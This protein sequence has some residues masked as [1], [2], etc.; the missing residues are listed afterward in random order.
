[1]RYVCAYG[2]QDDDE[3]C[4]II[5]RVTEEPGPDSHGACRYHADKAL[6]EWKASQ[7]MPA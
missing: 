5:L 7:G 4:P 3:S 6:R 1:M 2:L